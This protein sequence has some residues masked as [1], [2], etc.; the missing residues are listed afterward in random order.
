M[1][2]LFVKPSKNNQIREDQTRLKFQILQ[3]SPHLMSYISQQDKRESQTRLDEGRDTDKG[4]KKR[5]GSP[6]W[7]ATDRDAVRDRKR[8]K[9][10]WEEGQCRLFQ[11]REGRGVF[12][13]TIHFL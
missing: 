11:G 6:S 4:D 5:Y 12:P 3:Q 10:D 8:Q 9:R 1:A 13:A 7:E 2:V